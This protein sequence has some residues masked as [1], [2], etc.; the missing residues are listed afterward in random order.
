MMTAIGLQGFMW[1]F[2][3]LL[4]LSTLTSTLSQLVLCCWGNYEQERDVPFSEKTS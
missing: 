2:D 4:G 1:D 3:K